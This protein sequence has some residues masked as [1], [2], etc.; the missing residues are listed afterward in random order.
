MG[1]KQ[2]LIKSHK[3][4]KTKQWWLETILWLAMQVCMSSLLIITHTVDNY[5]F[6]MEN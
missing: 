1:D 3:K 5:S 2:F 6:N 4:R